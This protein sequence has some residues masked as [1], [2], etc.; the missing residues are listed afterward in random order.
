MAIRSLAGL[1][2]TMFYGQIAGAI[3]ATARRALLRDILQTAVSYQLPI[4][5]NLEV[6]NI[7]RR[8]GGHISN[9]ALG[10]I[11][12]PARESSRLL[13][14]QRELPV[15]T[16]IPEVMMPEHPQHLSRSYLYEVQ[17]MVIP[18]GEDDFALRT[19]RM[20]HD[21]ELS[22]RE[23]LDAFYEANVDKFDAGEVNWET[24]GFS[25]AYRSE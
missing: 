18:Y 24:M 13:V 19:F 10:Q 11:N 6:G 9:E 14:D 12:Q 17:V 1:V 21:N 25:G 3:T 20:T 16:V 22:P 23:V 2:R 5:T 4:P 15:H 7:F 8:Y